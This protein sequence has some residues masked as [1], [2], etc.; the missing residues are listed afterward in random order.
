MKEYIYLILA[1]A[2]ISV[3][4]GLAGKYGALDEIPPQK[5]IQCL[6]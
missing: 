2:I 3:L 4:I 6:E 5:E 1:T